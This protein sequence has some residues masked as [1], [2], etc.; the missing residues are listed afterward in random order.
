M[1][2]VF[3]ILILVIITAGC[4][5]TIYERKKDP[6]NPIDQGS[7]TEIQVRGPKAV[8]SHSF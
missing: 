6:S 5:R 4:S 3:L 2:Y 7:K 1:K 8:V